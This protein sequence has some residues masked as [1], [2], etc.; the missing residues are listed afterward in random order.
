MCLLL[1]R[2]LFYVELSRSPH[3]QFGTLVVSFGYPYT[4]AL[5]FLYGGSALATPVA[6]R[7]FRVYCFYV[8]LLG[9]NGTSEAFFMV[10]STPPLNRRRQRRPTRCRSTIA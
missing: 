1:L 6:I 9:L 3:S 5:L 2:C 8:L 4:S 7:M 10:R